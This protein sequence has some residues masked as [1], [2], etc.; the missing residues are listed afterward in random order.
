MLP[1]TAA[2]DPLPLLALDVTVRQQAAEGLMA[3]VP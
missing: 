1:G 2:V 3:E